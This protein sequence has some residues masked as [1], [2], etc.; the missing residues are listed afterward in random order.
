[1]WIFISGRNYSIG[2]FAKDNHL[3]AQSM[4]LLPHENSWSKQARNEQVVFVLA[5]F[6]TLGTEFLPLL[7]GDK[8]IGQLSALRT[9]DRWIE[10]FHRIRAI[11]AIPIFDNPCA[12]VRSV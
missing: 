1:M 10:S 12:L 3:F 5:V 7:K 11:R 9:F 6:K 2:S 8:C 4:G